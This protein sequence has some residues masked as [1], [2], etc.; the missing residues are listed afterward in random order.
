MKYNILQ[1]DKNVLLFPSVT[2][3]LDSVSTG[4]C[5]RL[6]ALLAHAKIKTQ[7]DMIREGSKSAKSASEYAPLG[8]GVH[9]R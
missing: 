1:L 4:S 5:G 3:D 8:P 6:H 7:H 2:A 9:I